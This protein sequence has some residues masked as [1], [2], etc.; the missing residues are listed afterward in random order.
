[1]HRTFKP[2]EL[3]SDLSLKVEM[4]ERDRSINLRSTVGYASSGFYHVIKEKK[5]ILYIH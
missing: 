1:M 3:V 4:K 5:D 2:Q